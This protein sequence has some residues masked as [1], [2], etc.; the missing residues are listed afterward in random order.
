[1][2][3]GRLL[4]KPYGRVRA[5]WEWATDPAVARDLD[6]WAIARGVDIYALAPDRFLNLVAHRLFANA[7][8]E[9]REEL[10]DRLREAEEA[11]APL[12]N[13]EGTAARPGGAPAWWNED[14]AAEETLGPDAAHLLRTIPRE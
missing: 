14:T 8:E 10:E 3:G 7:T 4:R 5:L 13:P 2:A 1:M 12:L 11:W 6:G 9:R